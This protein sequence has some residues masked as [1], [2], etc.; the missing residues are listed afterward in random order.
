VLTIELQQEVEGR[1]LSSS[2]EAGFLFYNDLNYPTEESAQNLEELSSKLRT[3]T[4]RSIRFH[5][6]RG[7]F[8]RWLKSIGEEG[9]SE[10]LRR[11]SGRDLTDDQLRTEIT[12]KC[13]LTLL[14]RKIE[15]LE[16]QLKSVA[17]LRKK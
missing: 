13:T 11:L 15:R 7:D 8:E 14:E 10:D 17:T 2:E 4:I 3:I 12:R 6:T 9:L 5:L 1:T 16:E